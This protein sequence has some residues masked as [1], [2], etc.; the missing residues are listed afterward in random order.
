MIIAIRDAQW[1]AFAI[2]AA[3]AIGVIP[4][5][6]AA[7]YSK[8]NHKTTNHINQAV[9]DVGPGEPTLKEQIKTI[10]ERQELFESQIET[11]STTLETIRESVDRRKKGPHEN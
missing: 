4:A 2:I 10:N 8:K 5:S 11:I 1:S 3:S 9:N 6:I 7:F